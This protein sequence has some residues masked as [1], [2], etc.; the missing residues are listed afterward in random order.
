MLRIPQDTYCFVILTNA[1]VN[2]FLCV[3]LFIKKQGEQ[4]DLG[5]TL[6]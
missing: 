5:V 3:L 6:A 1:A 4:N 2:L